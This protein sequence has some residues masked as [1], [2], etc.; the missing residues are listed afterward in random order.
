MQ[1]R[2]VGND[3]RAGTGGH[4]QTQVIFERLTAVVPHSDPN[5]LH[6]RIHRDENAHR[7]L[8][9][10]QATKEIGNSRHVFL[11]MRNSKIAFIPL[12]DMN[13][14][15]VDHRTLDNLDFFVFIDIASCKGCCKKQH[16]QYCKQ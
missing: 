6:L 15:G 13:S 10:K 11:E 9:P 4:L 8:P 1:Q 2:V 12:W 5:G 3:R 7:D 14:I 16:D